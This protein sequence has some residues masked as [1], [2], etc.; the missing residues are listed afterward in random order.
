MFGEILKALF[1]VVFVDFMDEITKEKP[2]P[3]DSESASH[4]SVQESDKN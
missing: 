1:V 3:S 4:D 2:K